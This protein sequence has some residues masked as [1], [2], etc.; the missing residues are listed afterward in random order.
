MKTKPPG[1]R[2][3][4]A[5]GECMFIREGELLAIRRARHRA[6]PA[7]VVRQIPSPRTGEPLN[8]F[9]GMLY[10]EHKAP[11]SRAR[12]VKGSEVLGYWQ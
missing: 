10:D 8:R 9:V 5:L 7:R 3:V 6:R 4:N 11:F 12:T 1:F 2:I